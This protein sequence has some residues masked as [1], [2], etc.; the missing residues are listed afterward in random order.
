MKKSTL[1]FIIDALMFLCMAAIAG[2]GFLIKYTLISGQNRW[3]VYNDNVELYLFGMDRHEWGSI[4][5]ILGYILLGLLALHIILHWKIVVTI[6]NRLIKRKQL[7]QLTTVIFIIVSALMIIVPF[8]IKPEIVKIEHDKGRHES[9]HHIHNDKETDKSVSYDDKEELDATKNSTIQQNSN[10]SVEIKGS[11][12]LDEV[13]K[14]YNVPIVY[15]K[16]KLNIPTS[17][18]DYEKIGRLRKEFD[19]KMKDVEVIINE[20]KEK[21][22]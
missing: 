18:S 1:N 3:I 15:I 4:H 5:L 16:A 7:K 9:I 14:K 19:I 20:Y 6:Y 17:V 12:T 10:S 22:E 8:L 11:M 13:S 2:I 21:D